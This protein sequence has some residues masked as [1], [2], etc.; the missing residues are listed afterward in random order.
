MHTKS[1]LTNLKSIRTAVILAALAL[2]LVYR[3][4]ILDVLRRMGDLDQ[5][6]SYLRGFGP[7]GLVVVFLLM[8]AQ[9]FIALIPGHA[10][11]MASGYV[12]GAPLTIAVVSAS[13]ILG[14]QIAFA[15]AR[16]S[17]RPLIYKLASQPVVERWDRLAGD[18]G[19]LFYFF[20]FVLPI[21]PSDLMCYVA[22]L[23][24]V[25]PGG[26]FA[27]NV[28]GRLL[29]TIA[30]TLIGSFALR[31][32]AWFWLLLAGCLAFLF[33]AWR[34]YDRSITGSGRE[35][36]LAR[37]LGLWISRTYRAV[38]AVRYN[39]KGL[40][41][42]PPGPKILAANHPS[43]TDGV[44]LPALFDED[45]VL[46]AEWHQ[47]HSPILGWI[48]TRGGHIPVGAGDP[49]KACEQACRKLSEGKTLLIFTEGTLNPD[50]ARLRART[51][52]VRLA[53]A[54]GVPIVPIGVYVDRKDTVNLR[55]HAF[56]RPHL[57]CFQFRGQ[58]SVR[59]GR[60]WQTGN[61]NAS[62]LKPVE[63]HEQTD[64]LMQQIRLLVQQTQEE[65]KKENIVPIPSSVWGL[66]ERR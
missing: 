1:S 55:F 31:P 28:A 3:L 29:C 44:L 12:Y 10:L 22:G 20:A 48:L 24:K 52:A 64:R 53:A 13:A 51:G 38:F 32:P 47:F 43:A 62:R 19:P 39:V 25:S 35:E 57:G 8:L 60:P 18:R 17:G 15:L 26:F 45:L 37:N 30:I 5:M 34:Y 40:E 9:V 21:F 66:P 6:D 2:A 14:S 50:Y 65:V 36:Q 54:A 27:A 4:P 61:F 49:R 59:V 63:V 33:L 42:L 56:G 16:R 58:Y 23:G 7:A 41:N 11:V 46:L